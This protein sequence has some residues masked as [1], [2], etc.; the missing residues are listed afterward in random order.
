MK[1]VGGLLDGI[2][3]VKIV[4]LIQLESLFNNKGIYAFPELLSKISTEVS[5]FS[6]PSLNI[7]PI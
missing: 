5:R 4:I 2:S 6:S 3:Y 7:L 1:E